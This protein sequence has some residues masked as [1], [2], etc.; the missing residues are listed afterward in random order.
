MAGKYR[1][2]RGTLKACGGMNAEKRAHSIAV[3]LSCCLHAHARGHP[4]GGCDGGKYGDHDVQDFAP[5]VFVH[6]LS[7]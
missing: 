1:T 2:F 4:K 3:A 7:E 6:E 5:D